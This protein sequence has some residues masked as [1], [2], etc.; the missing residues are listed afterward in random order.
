M[1]NVVAVMGSYIRPETT[2]ESL[3]IVRRA[4]DTAL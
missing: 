2:L 3:E 1:A 4:S